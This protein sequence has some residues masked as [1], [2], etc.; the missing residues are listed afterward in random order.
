MIQFWRYQIRYRVARWLMHAGLFVWPPGPA[1]AEIME[2]LW[3][4]RDHVDR[5]I[6]GDVA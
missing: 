6:A 3:A 2:I 5:S 1:K 4:W